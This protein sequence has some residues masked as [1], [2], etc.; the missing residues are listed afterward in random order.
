MKRT[1][2]TLIIA[3]LLFSSCS[4]SEKQADNNT[5]FNIADSIAYYEDALFSG[6]IKTIK[7]TDAIKLADFY[8]QYAITNKADT[9]SP[10]N[11]FKAADIYSN[12]RKPNKAIT[13]Y[14]TILEKYPNSKNA[15]AALFLT[16]F[17]YEDQLHDLANAEKY[18]KLYL[19]KYPESD[20][21]DDAEISLKNL[22]KTP[23][24]LIEEFEKNNK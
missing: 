6:K 21:A 23:E 16:A 2:Y 24:Q 10:T 3:L 7:T 22:G 17:I 11:V 4:N 12:F 20:F 14:K 8:M 1:G 15:S 13:A 18:Y 19:E 5:E 9:N